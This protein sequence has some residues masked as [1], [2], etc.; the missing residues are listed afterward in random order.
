MDDNK[1]NKFT[2]SAWFWTCIKVCVIIVMIPLVIGALGVLA[3]IFL[4]VLF[5]AIPV[6]IAAVVWLLLS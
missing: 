3:S 6:M 2:F 1:K 4:P 5:I